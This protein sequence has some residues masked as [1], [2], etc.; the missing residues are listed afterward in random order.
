MDLSFPSKRYQVCE[1]I[2]LSPIFKI[3]D[4][5][6]ITTFETYSIVERR[7]IWPFREE[8]AVEM[9]D[10]EYT[11][12]GE[13]SSAVAVEFPQ[14]VIPRDTNVPPFRHFFSNVFGV[15]TAW[16]WFVVRDLRSGDKIGGYKR[17]LVSGAFAAFYEKE[18]VDKEKQDFLKKYGDQL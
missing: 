4:A 11:Y 6:A 8:N 16:P 2:R 9:W 15:Y 10:E 1:T 12:V 14:S 5:L 17:A 18:R 13:Y 3:K 7:G